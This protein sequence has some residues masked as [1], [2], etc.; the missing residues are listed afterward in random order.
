MLDEQISGKGKRGR[1]EKSPAVVGH[2]RVELENGY[3]LSVAEKMKQIADIREEI[4]DILSEAKNDGFDKT[5]I[6]KAAALILKSD[7]RRIHEDLMHEEAKR[8]FEQIKSEG[9]LPLFAAA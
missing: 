5:P 7:E 1:G 4:K 3:T 8:V 9:K 2:N 6:R